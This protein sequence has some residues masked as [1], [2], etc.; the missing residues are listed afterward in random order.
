[1]LIEIHVLVSFP[2]ANR[3]PCMIAYVQNKRISL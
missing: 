1:M 3:N 2:N